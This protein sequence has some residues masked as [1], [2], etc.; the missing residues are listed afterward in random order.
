MEKG[1]PRLRPIAGFLCRFALLF[2][3]LAAPWPNRDRL[4]G[5]LYRKL[6]ESVFG[7]ISGNREITFEANPERIGTTRAVLVN[8]ALMAS[9]GSGPV[10]NFDIDLDRLALRPLALLL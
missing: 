5:A 9:D 3:I 6:T 2:A 8:R 10:R 4:A 7:G 1:M